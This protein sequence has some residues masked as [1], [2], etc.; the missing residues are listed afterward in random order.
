VTRLGN[1]EFITE[2]RFV[3]D[4]LALTAIEGVV[5]GGPASV[6]LSSGVARL[7]RQEPPMHPEDEFIFLLHT[8]A[9]V[10]HAFL[11]QYLYMAYSLPDQAP[12]RSWRRTLLQIAREEM[13][14][15]LSM[16]NL[17]ISVGAPLCL[18]R[19]DEPFRDLVPFEFE[20][21]PF[22][23]RSVARFVLAEMPSPELIPSGIGFDPAQL[24][25][26]AE[27]D[28]SLADI[29]RVGALF[30]LLMDL[31]PEL[32]VE[33]DP[34]CWPY[35]AKP[36]EWRAP[37]NQLIVEEVRTLADVLP[38][39]VQVSAQG[40]GNTAP[41]AGPPSHFERLHTIY[42][43]ARAHAVAHGAGSLA[44]PVAHDPTRA[45]RDA[46]GYVR[47]PDA[48]RW[49]DVLNHRYRWLLAIV[50]HVLTIGDENSSRKGDLVRWAFEEMQQT[51]API[52]E[53]LVTLPLSDRVG[54]TALAGPPFDL[55]YIT[56]LSNRAG[57]LW[58]HQTML[59]EHARDQLATISEGM[60]GFE[61]AERIRAVDAGRA[62]VIAAAG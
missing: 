29:T 37:I 35:Q 25:A 58:R 27:L 8:A 15:L 34:R 6:L 40:E 47:H 16:Q 23:L 44:T 62:A 17:L 45:D 49:A 21:A 5:E 36:A 12:H 31:V 7:A 20:L 3:N 46:D 56:D 26:D 10:E 41:A 48:A 4:V 42:V 60:V 38:L 2:D 59:M 1:L 55:P 53:L 24:L 61:L 11:V 54:S 28:V 32:T 9:E 39:L 52:S 57:D 51:I 33:P 30:D 19:D 18:G 14:H 43:A 22:S 50:A 13:G